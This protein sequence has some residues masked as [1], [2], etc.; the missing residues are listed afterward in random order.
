MA[1]CGR[2]ET[3]TPTS[4]PSA[5]V[6]ST[7]VV[8]TTAPDIEAT[9]VDAVTTSLATES[10]APPTTQADTGAI[11]CIGPAGEWQEG[12]AGGRSFRAMVPPGSGPHPVILEFH[13]FGGNAFE[14]SDVSMLGPV[15][16]ANGFLV[17]VFDGQGRPEPPYRW[18]L[19]GGNDSDVDFID[20][21][22]PQLV[23]CA[24]PVFATGFSNGAAFAAVLGC[25]SSLDVRAVATV[26][27]AVPPCPDG[28]PLAIQGF[29]GTADGTVPYDGDGA[30]LLARLLGLGSGP[31][32]E[33][34]AAWAELNG[35]GDR[36]ET[37]VADD[38]VLFEW[39]DCEATTRFFRI[40]NGGH[41]WP[42]SDTEVRFGVT[43]KSISASELIVEFFRS[44]LG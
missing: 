33:A 39:S 18:D 20:G 40:D 5:G 32:E 22:L 37:A 6:T 1:A 34:I 9:V 3:A 15:G 4:A 29:H 38:V 10:S 31:A 27:Y 44:Q 26:S 7:S 14:Q 30:E 24:G 42:G 13:G 11:S 43:T 23:P 35:C 25:E 2:A 16:S 21:I 28:A 17:V 19:D 36:G 41:S 12:I 8:A